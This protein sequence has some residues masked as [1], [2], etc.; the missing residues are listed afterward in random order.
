[1]VEG[2]FVNMT[3]GEY[4][5]FPAV[6]VDAIRIYLIMRQEKHT[7]KIEAMKSHAG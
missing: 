5:D 2:N 3:A 6:F 1:M 4:L 7:A